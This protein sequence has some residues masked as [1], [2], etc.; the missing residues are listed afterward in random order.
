MIDIAGTRL[1]DLDRERLSHP[2]VGG[3]ILFSRNYESPAQLQALCEEIHALRMMPIAV[4]HE[5]G[6][7]Q[8][9]REGFTR[10][11]AMRKL[12]NWWDSDP[13]AAK[14]AAQALGFVLAAELRALGVDLSFAP[15]LDLDWSRSGV[16][17]DRAFHCDPRAV[18]EL[19]G[20]LIAG[21]RDAGMASCG[22]HF[23]GHGWVEA[24]SHVAIPVDERGLG[25]MAADMQPYR[26][27]KLDGVMPAHV[28][29]PKIDAR[30]AGF[31]PVWIEMLRKELAF[32]GVIFSDD[33]S[34]E[35][36]SVAGDIVARADAAWG[37]GCDVLLVCNAP[38][39]VGELL[40]RWQPRPDAVRACRIERLLPS[41][42]ALAQAELERHPAYQS[43][44][45]AAVGLA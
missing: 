28:I 9:F 42:P 40:A 24:D 35:G 25:E 13:Q 34:M 26:S 15:V 36:A 22:K 32:D 14:A 39:A 21:L 11:P 38:D 10:L 30:P 41:Q 44:R 3:M 5:G 4:D 1:S 6:R 19:A 33:L 12:G 7:V 8:R 17:G 16:I 27:L 29:Y 37:A 45:A 20:S 43:G 2:L 23:P 31:S 18:I